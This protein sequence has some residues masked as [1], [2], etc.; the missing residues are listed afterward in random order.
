MGIFDYQIPDDLASQIKVGQFI[1]IPFRQSIKEG[2]VLKIKET[3]ITGK[4]IK[5]IEKIIDQNPILTPEQIQLAEWMANYYFVS[6][7]TIIKTMLPPVPKNKRELKKLLFKFS[8]KKKFEKN[9]YTKNILN[10]KNNQIFYLPNDE[11]DKQ[12]LIENIIATAK[13]QILIILP[14]IKDIE[15]LTISLPKKL[16]ELVAV[17][18]N[19]LNK[20]QYYHAWQ[21]I[22][23]NQAKII[24][25]T[26]LALFTPLIKPELLILDQASNQNHKQADQ[27]PRYDSRQV[28]QKMSE[29]YNT[30]MLLINP[31]LTV[32][33][34]FQSTQKKLKIIDN[35]S[36]DND[37][38][39]IDMKQE[40]MKKNFS[41]FSD[42]LLINITSALKN[43]RKVF[44]FINKRGMA[45][46]VICKDC[47]Q[48]L[49]CDNCHQ[50]LTYHEKDQTLYCHQCNKKFELPP[51]CPNCHGP[52]FKFIGTGTQKIEL[53][54]N[55]LFSD[56][57]II[58]L[59]QDNKEVANIDKFDII[60]GT[61]FAF[62]YVSWDKMALIGVISADTLLYLPDYSSAERTWLLLKNLIYYSESPVFI[63]T[64][65]PDNPA[66]KYLISNSDKYYANELKEREEL[67]YPPY[68]EI[69]KLIFNHK[70]KNVCL[71]ETKRI[72]KMIQNDKIEISIITP[73][74]PFKQGKWQMYIMIKL[75]FTMNQKTIAD[76]IKQVPDNWIIDRN[77]FSLL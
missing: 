51:F 63:Q 6:L 37:I 42:Q 2:V 7:G 59:D 19:S 31:A 73:L 1:A 30:K 17:I 77:P 14:T 8:A 60:I 68:S 35:K 48:T 54:I 72:Y 43:N 58:R 5:P 21:T 24:I 47:G 9:F 25:G 57:N 62:P 11:K 39:I 46:S 49:V 3:A 52:N 20:T 22:I 65:N 34:Y 61:E 76:I 67:N 66:L 33:Q 71:D 4:R 32:S 29:L 41:I 28:I 70:D 12:S 74:N 50:P 15:K 26:K 55:R 40:Q 64:Y 56:K 23:T 13:K 45:S 10:D 16:V 44:L 69:V 36:I 75:N 53:E 38:E 18:N 27:N